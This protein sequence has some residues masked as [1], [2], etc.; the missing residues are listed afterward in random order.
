[1]LRGKEGWCPGRRGADTASQNGIPTKGIILT[2]I[3]AKWFEVLS[4][5]IPGL[6]HHFLHL[7][8]PP[9]SGLTQDEQEMLRGRSMTVRY[10]I[11]SRSATHGLLAAMLTS[12]PSRLKI[13]PIEAIGKSLVIFHLHIFFAPELT[14]I[15]QYAAMSPVAP[16]Q[17]EHP[18]APD[19]ITS[20]PL[21]SRQVRKDAD[22]PRAAAAR[23]PEAL[24]AP[25]QAH[26][27]AVHQGR[28]RRQGH[29][30]LARRG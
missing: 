24:R 11:Q 15:P 2:L 17:S 1:M 30:H 6:K 4:S 3:S 27:H 29:Q 28:A 8:L 9:A 19:G 5:R 14:F 22:H 25:A 21:T 23:R 10:V 12:D 7:G 18:L 20:G 13:F 26:L 16:G